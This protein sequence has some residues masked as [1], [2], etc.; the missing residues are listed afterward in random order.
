MRS[1]TGTQAAIEP[2]TALRTRWFPVRAKHVIHLRFTKIMSAGS[3]LSDAGTA[4]RGPSLGDQ[5]GLTDSCWRK[6]ERVVELPRLSS[7]WHANANYSLQVLRPFQ[8]I[9]ESRDC[10]LSCW[11][12]LS[13]L[14]GT[15]LTD[16]H[17]DTNTPQEPLVR[18]IKNKSKIKSQLISSD[19]TAVGTTG[20]CN[21]PAEVREFDLLA[22]PSDIKEG[23]GA[24]SGHDDANDDNDDRCELE[25]RQRG[26]I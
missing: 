22:S 23:G 8:V 13:V 19:K 10:K 15:L 1:T 6:F 5:R 18:R 24:C 2:E 3:A 25:I 20:A 17:E 7:H 9:C 11:A 26:A 4:R 14:S 12:A 16:C 21:L